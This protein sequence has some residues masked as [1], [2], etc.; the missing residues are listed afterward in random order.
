MTD[1]H[2]PIFPPYAGNP[3]EDTP[4]EG[5]ITRCPR[6]VDPDRATEAVAAVEGVGPSTRDLIA[7]AGGTAPYLHGLIRREGAWLSSVIEAPARALDAEL[8]RIDALEARD[9]DSGLRQAKRRIA[10]LSAL[11]DLGG[12]WSLE[13]VT[14]ALTRLA[15]HATHAALK[16]HVGREISRGKVPGPDRG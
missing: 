8:A 5:R 1:T 9:L 7:G 13:E 10:L 15:D 4:V 3:A 14:G 16:V 11:C 12:V 2:P 6:V